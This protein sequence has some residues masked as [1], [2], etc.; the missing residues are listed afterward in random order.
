MC[1]GLGMDVLGRTDPAIEYMGK[2]RQK[3][4]KHKRHINNSKHYD[5]GGQSIAKN[6]LEGKINSN[7]ILTV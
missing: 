3:L 1:G 4:I 6:H 7:Y 5:R 2:L